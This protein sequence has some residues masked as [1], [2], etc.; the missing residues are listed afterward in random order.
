MSGTA[1]NKTSPAS[2]GKRRNIRKVTGKAQARVNQR[3]AEK[4]LIRLLHANFTDGDIILHLTYATSSAPQKTTAAQR[5]LYNFV[6]RTKRRYERAELE[7]K[8][9][10][11]TEYSDRNGRVHHHLIISGGLNRDELEKLWRKGYAN[12][13]IL[14][15]GSE[16]FSRF[17]ECAGKAKVY[18]K[19]WNQSRNLRGSR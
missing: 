19:R 10:S 13:E 18:Y 9:I 17:A 1:D 7:C 2:P 8:Y 5:D 6:R 14:Q 4:K 12:S 16:A 15:F 11:C 3:N